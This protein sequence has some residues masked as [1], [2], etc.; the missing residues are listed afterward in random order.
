MSDQTSPATKT[1]KSIV[2]G[3]WILL[4]FGLLTA[5]GWYYRHTTL[6]PSTDDAYV[7]AHTVQISAQ[8]TG[9]VEEILVK[10][11]QKVKKGQ[12]LFTINAQPFQYA[13]NKAQANFNLSIQAMG[14]NEAAVKAA[15]AQLAQAQANYNVAMKNVPRTLTLVAEQKLPEAQ[16]VKAQGQLDVAKAQLAA[17][18]SKLQQAINNLGKHGK[19][20]AQVLS[21]QAILN[22][23]QLDLK[24]THVYAPNSGYLLN[25]T[26]R[27]GQMVSAGKPLFVL[28]ENQQWWVNANFKE[29]DLARIKPNQ[30][31]RIHIDIY[32][33][34]H[35]KGVVQQISRGSGAAFSL[36][37]PENATGNWVK[38]TQRFPVKIRIENPNANYPLRVGASA[39]VT[40]DTT[41]S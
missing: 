41:Q 12:L 26:L 1:S 19:N 11:Y 17:S 14:A 10:N 34:H 21:A 38:V 4:I 32:P 7:R 29:T 36:L 33:H 39:T 5:G 24:H 2:I 31:A 6:F 18:Q 16:G 15:E 27:P 8:V 30:P 20:N 37:P 40:I 9:P 3:F 25:V 13:V 22:Q 35:F 28:V 23:A